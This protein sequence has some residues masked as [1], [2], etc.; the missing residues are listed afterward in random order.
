MTISILD[1][2]SLLRGTR[3]N[4]IGLHSFK[5]KRGKV[6]LNQSLL[7]QALILFTHLLSFK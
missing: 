5:N 1:E 2:Q 4:R 3:K 7:S 6:S